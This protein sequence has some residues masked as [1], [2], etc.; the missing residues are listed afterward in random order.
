MGLF[1]R[2][3]GKLG[4][5]TAIFLSTLVAQTGLG[6]VTGTVRDPSN[7]A[8]PNA[9]V[10]LTDTATGVAHTAQTNQA[11]IYY[12][13]SLQVGPYHMA[14]EAP[15]FT[16]WETDF[17]IQAG[18]TVTVDATL[19]VG[20]VQTKVEVTS[21]ASPIATEGAQISDVKTALTIHDLPL[22]GRQI[23]NL[24][25][26]TPGVEGGQNTQN[27]SNPRTNGMTV[28]STEMLLDG[29]SYVDR[30]GGGISRVQPGLDTI[31]E[32]R[33]ETAGSG[34]EF[35]RPAT[36]E[37][38]TRSGTNAFHG[39][40]Y[41]TFRNNYGGLV[42]RAVSDGNTPA[43]LIRNEFGGWVGGPVIKNKTFFFYDQELWR[44]R[45]QIFA[46][47]AV[48]TAAMWNGDF[49]NAVDTSGDKITIYNPYSTNAQGLRTPFPGNVIP[50]SLLNTQLV[51][52]FKSV[53]PLPNGPNAGANPWISE[54][55]QTY[56]PQATNA[57]TLTAKID[58][59]FSPKDSLSGRYTQSLY[60]YLQ[61]GGHYGFPPPGV[62]NA[63]GTSSQTA[64]VYNITTHWTHVFTP[65][66]LE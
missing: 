60:N 18:Q 8:A 25:T 23:S 50:Q 40:A 6:I 9:V 45:Q 11:G 26:L 4:A 43:K 14:V 54:N 10:T 32:Y 53:T 20:N 30:F 38:V 66:L 21:A 64:N 12:F 44:Q 37:L 33:I 24:F 59:V 31:Q 48:P 57:N 51:N 36:I 1:L 49:S 16:K 5:V 27:G 28:G 19:A 34:A 39:A 13:G 61:N 29:M 35:D 47:T 17:L 46:Q 52:A 3:A 56:Y 58:Q 41:E 2:N 63:T 62:T 55:Y 65:G 15:G 7:A 22:N 42:A